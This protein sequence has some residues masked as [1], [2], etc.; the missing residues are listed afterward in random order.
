MPIYI[1]PL[2]QTGP[3]PPSLE[4][5]IY[6][7]ARQRYP[8]LELFIHICYSFFYFSL[9]QAFSTFFWEYY[10]NRRHKLSRTYKTIHLIFALVYFSSRK[11]FFSPLSTC[12]S[13][14]GL[15]GF[16]L[17]CFS[18]KASFPILPGQVQSSLLCK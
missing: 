17:F 9:L 11:R 6:E 3:P 12:V 5:I 15:H 10:Y 8:K 2:S 4:W 14:T 18:K 1:Q 7:S 16:S 13:F